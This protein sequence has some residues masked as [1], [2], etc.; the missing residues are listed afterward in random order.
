MVEKLLFYLFLEKK[1]LFEEC[2]K[3][4]YYSNKVS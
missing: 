2:F 1:T 4:V 3:K